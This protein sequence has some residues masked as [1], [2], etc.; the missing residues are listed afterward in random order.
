[1]SIEDRCHGWNLKSVIRICSERWLGSREIEIGATDAA[2][3]IVDIGAKGVHDT[4]H[5]KK[6]R[7]EYETQNQ[8][9]NCCGIAQSVLLVNGLRHFIL[10]FS[11]LSSCLLDGRYS[12]LIAWKRWKVYRGLIAIIMPLY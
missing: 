10:S 6:D 11:F 9:C 7:A 2:V 12:R 4:Q 3:D 5:D 1:M 8:E